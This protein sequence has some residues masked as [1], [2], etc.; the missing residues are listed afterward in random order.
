RRNLAAYSNCQVFLNYPFDKGF[1]PIA[2][3]LNFAVIA[4]GL[5]PVCAYDLT[6]PDQPRLETIVHA[7]R[8]CHYSAHDF[9]RNTGEGI[10]NFSRMNMPIEMGMAVFHALDSQR[11]EHRCAF[12]VSTPNDYKAFAS[13]LAGLDPKCH[14][15]NEINALSEMYDWL[16]NIVPRQ[17]FNSQPTIKIVEKF[18]EF[19]HKVSNINGCGENGCASH[20]ETR[21][22]MY[23]ICADNNWWD[24]RETRLGKEEFPAIP[25]E[26]KHA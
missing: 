7:I 1:I 16:R 3:A 11:S 25:I 14:G 12:F 8:C 18:K 13:D 6:T 21:E 9:S 15:N 2:N 19:I 20:A 26:W 17:L 10:N 5:L 24:W 4:G 23:Q 22:L